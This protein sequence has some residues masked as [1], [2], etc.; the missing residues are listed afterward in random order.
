MVIKIHWSGCHSYSLDKVSYWYCHEK[1]PGTA[2]G[3]KK[4]LI[5]FKRWFRRELFYLHILLNYSNFMHIFQCELYFQIVYDNWCLPYMC[6]YV[7][8][9]LWYKSK[10]LYMKITFF[11]I[12]YV[13]FFEHDNQRSKISIHLHIYL[14]Y[15]LSQN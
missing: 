5:F 2:S 10:E 8:M 14:E 1:G 9:C 11:L 7:S 3:R 15:C 12:L 6:E 4:C 13:S